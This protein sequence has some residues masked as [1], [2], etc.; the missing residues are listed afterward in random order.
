VRAPTRHVGVFVVALAAAA[1]AATHGMNWSDTGQTFHFA[2]RILRGD[3]P[4]RDF[5]YQTGFVGLL[6]CATAM[7]V[8]GTQALVATAVRLVSAALGVTAMTVL[9]GRAAGP[10][11]ATAIG[12]GA[13]I[14]L[15]VTFPQLLYAGGNELWAILFGLTGA[16]LLARAAE[17]AEA[18]GRPRIAPL[19]AGCS[20][21]LVLGARQGDGIVVLAVVAAAV[22]ALSRRSPG[23]FDARLTAL[24]AAGV[25]AGLALLLATLAAE[26]A[27]APGLRELFANAAEK[28][29]IDPLTSAATSVVGGLV[30]N[31]SR[32]VP[33]VVLPGLVAVAA[34]VTFAGGRRL[35]DA[36]RTAGLLA[37][38]A[39]V[40]AGVVLLPFG[41]T[42]RTALALL[43]HPTRIFLTLAAGWLLIVAWRRSG[44]ETAVPGLLLLAAVP[45]AMVWGHGLSFTGFEDE[46]HYLLA[47]PC[48]ALAGTDP[49]LPSRVRRAVASALV[50]AALIV[51]GASFA[52]GNLGTNDGRLRTAVVPLDHPM[53]RG[54]RVIPAK[55]IALEALRER[56]RPGDSLFIYG[57]AAPLYTLLDAHNPTRLDV[58]FSDAFTAEQAR[59]AVAALRADPPKWIIEA[60]NLHH[61]FLARDDDGSPGFYG[62]HGQEAP[63]ILHHGLTEMRRGYRQVFAVHEIVGYERMQPREPIDWDDVTNL[64][65]WERRR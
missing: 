10:F 58:T 51:W 29:H 15:P 40:L 55:A 28:K 37:M 35:P 7:K 48:F 23:G 16:A 33:L 14:L 11:A 45:L 65:L 32:T 57:S 8:L 44:R 12:L 56:I 52:T 13:A 30:W 34:F 46:P 6:A 59:D 17:S 31:G 60:V 62:P 47:V 42:H 18:G 21:A 41:A 64:R 4:Y 26:S 19:L 20:F 61:A 54:V 22:T 43:N 25:A 49:R 5:S 39:F 36:V 24:L 27:L 9:L 38:P 1:P 63:R 2:C 50:G 53:T 3:F